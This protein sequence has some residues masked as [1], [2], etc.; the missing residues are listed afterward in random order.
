MTAS[1]V[2]EERRE[3]GEG[4]D[5]EESGTIGAEEIVESREK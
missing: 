5:G 4:C 2:L 3:T 1:E